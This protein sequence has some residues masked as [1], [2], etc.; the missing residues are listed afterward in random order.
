MT[1]SPRSNASLKR[2]LITTALDIES[3][4][5]WIAEHGHNDHDSS[6]TFHVSETSLPR[7]AIDVLLLEDRQFFKHRGFEFR[8]I[9]RGFKRYYKV[10]KIGGISTIEQQLVRTIRNRRERKIS[11]KLSEISLATLINFHFSKVAILLTYLNSVYF[12]PHMNGVDTASLVVFGK[13]A[14]ELEDRESAFI[15]CL[16]PTPMP[17]NVA[18]YLRNSGP[19][20]AYEH[21]FDQFLDDNPWWVSSMK[22]RIEVLNIAR[23]KYS[24]LFSQASY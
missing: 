10:G 1:G 3:V 6:I 20:T 13:R 14:I 21:L 17:R 8:S 23:T 12:G 15:S 2:P 4:K 18:K 9:P 22:T 11:R 5:Q 19:I 7:I 24:G 16:L